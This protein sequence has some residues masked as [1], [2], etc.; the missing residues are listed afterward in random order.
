MPSFEGLSPSLQA[1]IAPLFTS[2]SSLLDKLKTY[3]STADGL[4][5]PGGNADT[6]TGTF[7]GT[8]GG[9]MMEKLFRGCCQTKSRQ[10]LVVVA[11]VHEQPIPLFQ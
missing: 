1:D 8:D 10:R 6:L 7:T 11:S 4:T 5:S 9:G 2:S 3:V